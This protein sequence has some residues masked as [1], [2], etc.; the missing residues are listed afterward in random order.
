M[1]FGKSLG[2]ASSFTEI[3]GISED[4][5]HFTLY[6]QNI[7]RAFH[8]LDTLNQ[9]LLF[10]SSKLTYMENKQYQYVFG[11]LFSSGMQ[12]ILH[13]A[14]LTTIF[15]R[16]ILH[17]KVDENRRGSFVNCVFIMWLINL[18]FISDTSV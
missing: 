8:G 7:F 11:S 18:H 12:S 13:K 9:L 14:A 1:V 4:F 5:R 10:P 6:L 3:Y 16:N 2:R 17:L 15:I